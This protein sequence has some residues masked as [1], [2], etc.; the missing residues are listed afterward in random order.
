[1][2]SLL[3][4]TRIDNNKTTDVKQKI[5]TN[6]HSTVDKNIVIEFHLEEF[7]HASICYIHN[8]RKDTL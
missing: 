4:F 7:G 6:A 1:M 8:V 5:I 3:T 2:V